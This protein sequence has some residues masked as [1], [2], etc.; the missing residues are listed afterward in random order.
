M[1]I[2]SIV[3]IIIFIGLIYLY[4]KL[5]DAKNI[6]FTLP[7]IDTTKIIDEKILNNINSRI[8]NITN[9]LKYNIFPIG[10]IL[11]YVN[12]EIIP[13]KFLPCDGSPLKITKFTKLYN[14][15]AVRPQNRSLEPPV[16]GR[17]SAAALLY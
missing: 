4:S 8:L 14:M 15:W 17:L 5:N 12:Q 2:N 7:P 11:Y 3:I 10:C 6:K 13:D 9:Y 16:P 1:I